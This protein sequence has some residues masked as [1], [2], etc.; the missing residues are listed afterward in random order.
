MTAKG[1]QRVVVAL[2]TVVGS[3]RFSYAL[4][5]YAVGTP[6]PYAGLRLIGEDVVRATCGAS[7]VD[8]RI[9]V[10][11]FADKVEDIIE[12]DEGVINAL[13]EAR[14]LAYFEGARDDLVENPDGGNPVIRRTRVLVMK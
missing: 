11:Y 8:Q 3:D 6:L 1:I 5:S 7:V 9:E 14:Q 4:R 12:K 2:D 13:T 10:Q